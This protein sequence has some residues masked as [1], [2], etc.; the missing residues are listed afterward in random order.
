MYPRIFDDFWIKNLSF[1]LNWFM[2]AG[3][4]AG[5]GFKWIADEARLNGRMRICPKPNLAHMFR[6]VKSRRGKSP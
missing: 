2:C 3:A 6:V 4:A 5:K 1:F